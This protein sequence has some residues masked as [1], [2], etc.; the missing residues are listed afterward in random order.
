MHLERQNVRSVPWVAEET[1]APIGKQ[2]STGHDLGPRMSKFSSLSEELGAWFW[3]VIVGPEGPRGFSPFHLKPKAH[4]EKEEVPGDEWRES[5]LPECTA[6]D[7]PVLDRPKSWE[8]KAP[9]R[10]RTSTRGS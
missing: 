5:K 1:L 7:D 9:R 10:R 2:D 6:E 4:A 3:G 8:K